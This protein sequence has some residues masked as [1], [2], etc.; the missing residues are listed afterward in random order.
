MADCTDPRYPLG[1]KVKA[2]VNH[3]PGMAGMTGVISIARAGAPPYYGV[4]FDGTSKVHKWLA[5]D[6]LTS[7]TFGGAMME[8]AKII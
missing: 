8:R 4:T 6:E 2:L 7:A 5:E 1:W 3:M